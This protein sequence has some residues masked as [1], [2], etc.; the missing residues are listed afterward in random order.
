MALISLADGGAPE[1]GTPFK[2]SPSFKPFPSF[3][4]S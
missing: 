3:T 1:K 4:L 2:T